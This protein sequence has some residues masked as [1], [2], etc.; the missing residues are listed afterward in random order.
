MK[1]KNFRIWTV[2]PNSYFQYCLP[3]SQNEFPCFQISLFNFFLHISPPQIEFQISLTHCSTS[4]NFWQRRLLIPAQ[5]VRPYWGPQPK[6]TFSNKLY[7]QQ[8]AQQ[9]HPYWGPQ[10][11][12]TFTKNWISSNLLSVALAQTHRR[13]RVFFFTGTPHCGYHRY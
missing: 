13:Y 9:V 5:Q 11:K 3:Y 8:F 4:S 7:Q 1:K 6:L 10:P 2:C 12:F